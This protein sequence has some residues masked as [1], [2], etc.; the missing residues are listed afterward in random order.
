M[1]SER[2]RTA[3]RSRQ[4]EPFVSHEFL[5]T[6]EQQCI[7]LVGPIVGDGYGSLGI[8]DADSVAE[9]GCDRECP[10]PKTLAGWELSAGVP[11]AGPGAD[12]ATVDGSECPGRS[13]DGRS[14]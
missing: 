5:T 6:A 11:V 8:S 14:S 2:P 9:L 13:L 12:R 10:S 1:V 7:A 3:E 4:V